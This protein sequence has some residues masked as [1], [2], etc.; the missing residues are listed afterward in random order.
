LDYLL[1]I[2]V[3][4][5]VGFINT[6]AGGGSA[7]ALPLLI[8]MGL[9]A[10]VA[11]GTNR[12]GVL[13]QSLMATA[14]F[15]QSNVFHYS[16]GFRSA[17]PAILGAI[18]GALFVTK[19]NSDSLEIIIAIV[20]L[21][22]IPTM[23]ID[24]K[25]LQ[26]NNLMLGKNKVFNAIIF[27]IIGFYGGFIQLG[28][29]FFFMF[30]YMFFSDSNILKANAL[31]VL[32]ISAY[33]IFALLIFIIHKQVHFT[34]GLLLGIG[35]VIGAWLATKAAIRWGEKFVKYFV[36]IAIIASIIKLLDII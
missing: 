21:L 25:K 12:L 29:G 15:K 17:L 3:G 11:N 9:P 16:D 27:F 31:K 7:L 14:S 10:D 6:L 1:L 32:T 36:I 8:F 34:Y 4:V 33:T 35:S 13:M 23:F 30:A 24:A 20:L 26:A 18:L 19:I 5:F 28:V 22:M 2:V